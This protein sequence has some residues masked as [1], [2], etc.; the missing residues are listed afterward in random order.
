MSLYPPAKPK[1]NLVSWPRSFTVESELILVSP[2]ATSFSQ[3]LVA[4]IPSRTLCATSPGSCPVRRAVSAKRGHAHWLVQVASKMQ[5]SLQRGVRTSLQLSVLNGDG[6]LTTHSV[7][8]A[9]PT[10]YLPRCRHLA[11]RRRSTPNRQASPLRPWT[12]HSSL[13]GHIDALPTHLSPSHPPHLHPTPHRNGRRQ[14][15]RSCI[16][17]S[18]ASRPPHRVAKVRSLSCLFLGA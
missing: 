6:P 9:Q 17:S 15:L 5:S 12:L 13:D 7:R 4:S 2:T 8:L 14:T 18:M 16:A 3:T 10:Q 1:W 11:S